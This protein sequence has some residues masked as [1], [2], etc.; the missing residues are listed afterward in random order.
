MPSYLLV[1]ICVCIRIP[2]MLLDIETC[3]YSCER[4]PVS[5]LEYDQGLSFDMPVYMFVQG[6]NVIM[7]IA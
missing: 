1:C 6:V 5:V 7:V 4:P 2:Q 3:V